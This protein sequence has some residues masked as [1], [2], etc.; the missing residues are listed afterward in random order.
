MTYI[1]H[2]MCNE[3]ENIFS[4]RVQSLS[5]PLI[6]G[7]TVLDMLKQQYKLSVRVNDWPIS[8]E[9]DKWMAEIPALPGCTAWGDTPEEAL[10]IIAD[11]AVHF[12]RDDISAN[13]LSPQVS[14]VEPESS[15]AHALTSETAEEFT[16]NWMSPTSAELIVAL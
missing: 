6:E 12:I 7:A 4:V 1:I 2:L 13:A 8:T 9:P 11:L 10:E 16:V 3:F 14:P 5:P 15:D